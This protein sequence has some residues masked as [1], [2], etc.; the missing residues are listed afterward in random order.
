MKLTTVGIDLA[1]KYSTARGQRTWQAD[2]QKSKYAATRW[3]I[4]L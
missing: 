2:Y 4:Y 1:K 3:Q